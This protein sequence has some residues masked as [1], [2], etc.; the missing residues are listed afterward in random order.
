MAMDVDAYIDHV[1]AETRVVFVTNPHSP[2][3][4]WM[5]EADVCR[6]VE[7][8]PHSLVVLD[9]AYVHY[10]GGPGYIHLVREYPHLAVLRTFSKAFGLAGLRV[11]FGI[12]DPS[13]IDALLAVK[14]TWNMGQLQIAGGVAALDDD[15]HV[16]RTVATII[17][18]RGYVE[19]LF[20]KVDRFRFVPG[21]RSNFFLI[22]IL[23]TDLDSTEVFEGLLQRGVIVKDGSVSFR[24]LDRRFMRSD[25]NL[26]EH[27]DRLVAALAAVP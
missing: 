10:S 7:A 25:V 21:S 22:E 5:S 8:A 16:E 27:M 12:A 20:E 23:D 9:E 11:G 26:P 6:V 24:G 1:T 4:T 18:S 3:G 14:P 13:V 19:D 17:E 2:S 15:E